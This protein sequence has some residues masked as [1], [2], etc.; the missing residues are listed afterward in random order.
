MMSPP[1][2]PPVSPRNVIEWLGLVAQIT[3]RTRPNPTMPTISVNTATLLMRDA[4]AIEMMLIAST[5]RKMTTVM[6]RL[7]VGLAA[8]RLRMVAMT[9]AMTT[10]LIPAAPTARYD[11]PTN[12]VNQPYVVLTS[13]APHW[14]E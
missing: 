9:G 5:A 13:R 14:Y 10:K 7:M 11:S 1:C 6:T 2:T 4:S 3:K 12:P 8:S